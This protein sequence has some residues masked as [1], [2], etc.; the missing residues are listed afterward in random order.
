MGLHR[1]ESIAASTKVGS[2]DQDSFE[3]RS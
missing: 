3:D 1:Q 2:R